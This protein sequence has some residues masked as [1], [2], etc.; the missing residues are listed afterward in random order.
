MLEKPLALSEV[1][2]SIPDPRQS[3][4][5]TY[6]LV[7]V[8]VVVVCAVICGADVTVHCARPSLEKEEVM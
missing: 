2:V 7:E 3:S 5:V 1:F 8:L 4:K 6:D